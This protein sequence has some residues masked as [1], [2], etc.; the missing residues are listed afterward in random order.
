[1]KKMIP[2]LSTLAGLLILGFLGLACATTSKPESEARKKITNAV[3]AASYELMMG[4]LK[5]ARIA[6]LFDSNVYSGYAAGDVEYN[7]VNSGYRLVDRSHSQ[8]YI[9]VSDEYAVETGK[10]AGADIVIVVYAN[11][12]PKY[13]FY[14]V[15]DEHVITDYSGHLI[16]KVLSVHTGEIIAIVRVEF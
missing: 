7:L 12:E 15:N 1:M 16:L 4:L 14:L 6:V 2:H 10:M 13:S 8:F 9:Y 11:A 5:N 3:N